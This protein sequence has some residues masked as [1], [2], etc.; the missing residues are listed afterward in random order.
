[1]DVSN[2]R[3]GKQIE[4]TVE[5]DKYIYHLS[6]TVEA[7][8]DNHVIVTLIAGRGGTVFRFYP[9]DTITLIYRIEER[10]WQWKKV[11]AGIERLDGEMVHCFTVRDTKGESFNRRE[12]YRVFIGEEV[13][14]R[15]RIPDFDRMK[16]YRLA[17]PEIKDISALMMVAECYKT[18]VI[19]GIVKDLSETGVGL[20]SQEKLPDDAELHIM[21]PTEYG[22]VNC[23]CT[24][25]RH[26]IEENSRYR[27][28]YGCRVLTI[29]NNITKI[30]NNIQRK[31]LGRSHK[32]IKI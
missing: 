15:R 30:L 2:L 18:Q 23:V 12:T 19:P 9:E 3:P 13:D 24:P 32:D 7:I 29:G 14:V 25:V 5:R 10:L 27:Y 20:Y 26:A 28:F 11:R 17:H 4:I 22:L 8:E 1:M 16:E 6:S 31:Q 21:L